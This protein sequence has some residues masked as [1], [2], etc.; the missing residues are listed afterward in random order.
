MKNS[1]LYNISF[2]FY[3]TGVCIST[4]SSFWIILKDEVNDSI[5]NT[6]AVSNICSSVSTLSG[7]IALHSLISNIKKQHKESKPEIDSISI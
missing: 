4:G 7:M 5:S 1:T 2:I 6:I 3:F